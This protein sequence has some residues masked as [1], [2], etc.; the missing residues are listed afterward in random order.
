[1]QQIIRAG[2][3]RIIV[4]AA[5]G[6]PIGE[7]GSRAMPRREWADHDDTKASST[8]RLWRANLA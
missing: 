7:A 3:A 6:K 1:M 5:L 2:R 4:E 8:R